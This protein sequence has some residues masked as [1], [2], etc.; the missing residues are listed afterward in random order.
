MEDIK[1]RSQIKILMILMSLYSQ[2]KNPKETS[3]LEAKNQ[4]K[5]S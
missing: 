3:K 1:I 5:L 2:A 4:R